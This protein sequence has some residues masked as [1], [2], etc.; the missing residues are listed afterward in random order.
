M[1]TWLAR[2]GRFSGMLSSVECLCLF[3]CS[4]VDMRVMYDEEDHPDDGNVTAAFCYC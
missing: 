4:L 1:L 3:G 2:P